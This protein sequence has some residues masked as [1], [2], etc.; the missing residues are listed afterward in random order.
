[1]Q[2]EY[3][4]SL[5]P[6]ARTYL[7]NDWGGHFK[8]YAGSKRDDVDKQYREQEL[9]RVPRLVKAAKPPHGRAGF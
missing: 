1:M 4:M 2:D 8:R 3:G 9:K 6:E 5:V 7:R